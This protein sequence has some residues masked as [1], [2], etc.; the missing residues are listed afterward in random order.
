MAGKMCGRQLHGSWCMESGFLCSLAEQDWKWGQV[1]ET[2][3]SNS[4][5]SARPCLLKVSVSSQTALTAG[6]SRLGVCGTSSHS[7]HNHRRD[8]LSLTDSQQPA[9][10]DSDSTLTFYCALRS[11]RIP[12]PSRGSPGEAEGQEARALVSATGSQRSHAA[13]L[14]GGRE[15]G[16]QGLWG[17]TL[18]VLYR[19][20]RPPHLCG[21]PLGG[22]SQEL[23]GSLIPGSTR[24]CKAVSAQLSTAELRSL[25]L[26]SLLPSC[27]LNINP[28]MQNHGCFENDDT[29]VLT[30][31]S[32]PT[33]SEGE[34]PCCSFCLLHR[35]TKLM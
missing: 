30:E 9:R 2:Q 26:A 12:F 4:L 18:R 1:A 33:G 32:R 27:W 3:S 13:A 19:D 21:F 20:S 22:R 16:R 29:V 34:F 14:R 24:T 31:C 7:S 28:K 35:N 23:L 8:L 17:Y 10:E 25:C 15:G 11:P 5:P 6:G